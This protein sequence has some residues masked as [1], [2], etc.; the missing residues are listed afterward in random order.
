MALASGIGCAIEAAPEGIP[1]HAW[2]F[3]EDQARYVV[4]VTDGAE[5]LLADAEKAGVPAR[6]VGRTTGDSLTLAGE[7]A[8]SLVAMRD[9]HEG[10]LPG[11]M[12]GG[13]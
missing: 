3:G 4:T 11:Y 12:A 5:A 2:L 8:I 9:A 13:A 6:I 7:R 10:W 1:A